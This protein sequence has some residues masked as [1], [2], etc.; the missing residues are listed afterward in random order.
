MVGLVVATGSTDLEN[1]EYSVTDTSRAEFEGQPGL[2][3]SSL[4]DL[5]YFFARPVPGSEARPEGWACEV[6]D[7]RVGLPEPVLI[8]RSGSQSDVA[9]SS[10]SGR[11]ASDS[12]LLIGPMR[13]G[14]PRTE[15]EAVR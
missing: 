5:I 12:I 13:A 11:A 14:S 6:R 2:S 15:G 8:V 1:V 10:R 3:S 7:D 9:L 4:Y